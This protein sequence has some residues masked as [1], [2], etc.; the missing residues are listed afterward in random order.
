ML[1]PLRG[2]AHLVQLKTALVLEEAVELG[3][4]H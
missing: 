4:I 2:N 3:S 1:L